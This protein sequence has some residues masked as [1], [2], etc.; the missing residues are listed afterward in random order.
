MLLIFQCD[1]SQV[2]CLGIRHSLGQSESIPNE[3]LELWQRTLFFITF[4][5]TWVPELSF[6]FRFLYFGFECK[7][8]CKQIGTEPTHWIYY[9]DQ[10]KRPLNPN[11]QWGQLPVCFWR[12]TASQPLNPYDALELCYYFWSYFPF[13]QTR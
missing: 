2:R 7:E 12:W 5:T 6:C 10:G 3:D 9:R 11:E 1:S 13:S 8:L 4:L